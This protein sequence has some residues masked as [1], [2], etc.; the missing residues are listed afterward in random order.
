MPGADRVL[1]VNGTGVFPTT[2]W[3]AKLRNLEG[4]AGINP[5]MLRLELEVTEPAFGNE[6]ITEQPIHEYAMSDPP[7]EYAEVEV[8]GEAVFEVIHT[9]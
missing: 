5:K 8:I 9:Q 4:N 2:G 7:I 3:S 1:R 6:V